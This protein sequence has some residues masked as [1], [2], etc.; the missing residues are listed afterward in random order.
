MKAILSGS[1]S[2]PWSNQPELDEKLDIQQIGDTM[3]E[4][5]LGTGMKVI[6]LILDDSKDVPEI[7]LDNVP[8]HLALVLFEQAAEA[9]RAYMPYPKI[10]FE[11]DT[12]VE[13]IFDDMMAFEI[14]WEDDDED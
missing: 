4:Y 7:H 10:T 8:P 14:D 5:D 1:T 11:G 3:N 13:N 12:I 2:G 6:T 9:L